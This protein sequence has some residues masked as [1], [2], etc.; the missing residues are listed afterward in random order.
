MGAGIAG[1]D[2]L[3]VAPRSATSASDN[4]LTR[5]IARN[6]Q[7]ILQEES[8]IGHVADAAGG[9]WY[10]E[11]LHNNWSKALGPNSKP[12]KRR[13]V[14]PP[15]QIPS[16]ALAEARAAFDVAV[17]KRA[18]P[19]VGVSEFPNLDE[20]PLATGGDNG[21]R[22]SA[23]YEHLR[24]AAQKAKPKVFLAN[25]GEMASFTRAPISPPI[26]MQQAGYMR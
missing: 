6:T 13:A 24:N 20:A 3:T 10:V 2:M 21:Y 14:F 25:I 26:F 19:L 5:R 8:H 16:T 1:V 22:L 4:A 7:V 17:D 18:M 15:P 12:L 11:N 9:S 23:A